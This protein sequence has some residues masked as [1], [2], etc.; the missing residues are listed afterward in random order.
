MPLNYSPPS[1]FPMRPPPKASLDGSSMPSPA[2][3]LPSTLSMQPLRPPL[4]GVYMPNSSDTMTSTRRPRLSMIA[5]ATLRQRYR[6]WWLTSSLPLDDSREPKLWLTWD[7][8]DSELEALERPEK[9][10]GGILE[11]DRCIR[12]TEISLKLP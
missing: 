2:P 11:N 9:W 12:K 10:G 7:I 3:Q 1:T 5:S 6:E 4:T 8:F